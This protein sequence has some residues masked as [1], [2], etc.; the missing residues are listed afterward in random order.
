MTALQ[1]PNGGVRRIVVGDV[2]RRLVA[3]TMA[4]QFMTR[5]EAATKPFQ[6]ALATRAGSESIARSASGHR[7]GPQSHSVV[8]RRSRSFRLDFTSGNDVC[9]SEDA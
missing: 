9:R 3:K 5:F 2:V 6:C 1:K 8:N 7:H 4:K